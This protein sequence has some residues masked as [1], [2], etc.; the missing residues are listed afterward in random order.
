MRFTG[1]PNLW[2]MELQVRKKTSRGHN[3]GAVTK[4]STNVVCFKR[5]RLSP[6]DA[7]LFFFLFFLL[8]LFIFPWSRYSAYSSLLIIHPPLTP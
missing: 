3:G 7:L 6:L 1:E 4:R 2:D 8:S 5:T